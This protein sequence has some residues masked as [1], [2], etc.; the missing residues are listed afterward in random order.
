[1]Q[2]FDL[3]NSK[4]DQ[5]LKKHA[6]LEAD[7]KRLRDTIASQNKTIDSM[8]QQLQSLEK[9]MVSVHLGSGTPADNDNMRR[10]LDAVISEIDKILNTLND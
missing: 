3:L 9:D 6:A 10:Q 1:M 5:L 7:N 8:S 4:L 2:S